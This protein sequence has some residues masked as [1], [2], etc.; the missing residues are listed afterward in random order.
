MQTQP[1]IPS[2]SVNEDRFRLRV[3]AKKGSYGS[4]N[5]WINAWVAD[6]TVRSLD[7]AC[8]TWALL[9]WGSVVKRRYVKCLLHLSLALGFGT[10]SAALAFHDMFV[11]SFSVIVFLIV[12]V[13]PQT[14]KKISPHGQYIQLYSPAARVVKNKTTI[15]L[16]IIIN[17]ASPN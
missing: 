7:N 16:I 4:F 11:T 5:S 8:H 14:V 17:V 13:K 15:G 2:G 1:S 9:W 12:Y 6:K 3:H 10:L